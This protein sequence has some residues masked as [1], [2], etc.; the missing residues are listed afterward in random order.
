MKSYVNTI[1]LQFVPHILIDDQISKSF[2]TSGEYINICDQDQSFL[3]FTVTGG[4]TWCYDFK[5]K[6][7]ST[8]WCSPSSPQQ[9]KN[10]KGH[11]Q[12]SKLKTIL[13]TF[14]NKER[15]IHKGFFLC[16]P[17]MLDSTYTFLT[18]CCSLSGTVGTRCSKMEIG[19]HCMTMHHLK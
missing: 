8:K 2:E 18:V 14:F 5:T 10:P 1:S 9:T 4:E 3:D 11:V 7:Q 19:G 12:K 15:I 6:S 16:W 13:I 17:N